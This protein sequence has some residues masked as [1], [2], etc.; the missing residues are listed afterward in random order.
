MAGLTDQAGGEQPFGAQRIKDARASWQESMLRRL[1]ELREVVLTQ[2]PVQLAARCGASFDSG[3]LSLTYWG[4]HVHITWPALTAESD[5]GHALSTFD[6]AMLL[7]YL[8][9]A[10]GA[11]MA[12]R[13]IAFRELP[14]GAFYHQ[15]FT[16]YSGNQLAQTFGDRPDDFAAAALALNGL[17]LPALAEHAFAFQA[18]PHIRLA[19]ALYPGD[20]DFPAKAAVLFDAAASH[21]MVTDGLALLGAGLARRLQKLDP[22]A[23]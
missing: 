3:R 5:Q 13:W 14:D 2:E 22:Q 21:Y 8:A 4:A 16:G 17:R 6:H 1:D 18:L 12:D 15:A 23:R 10:D 19:A 9:Q 7:Y 20:E 11:P